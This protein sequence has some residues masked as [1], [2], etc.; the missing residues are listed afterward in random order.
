[1]LK[2][3]LKGLG[4]VVLVIVLGLAVVIASNWTYLNRLATFDR[5]TMITDYDWYDPIEIAKGDEGAP[6]PRAPQGAL[7]LQDTTIADALSF[8]ARNRS[9]ALLVWHKGTLQVEHY[10]EGYNRDTR[11]NSASMHKSVMALLYGVVIAEGIIPSLDEPAATYITE[12]ADDDRSQVTI[13]NLLQMASGLGRAPFSMNPFSDTFKLMM[14]T[15]INSLILKYPLED[16]PNTVF[17]YSNNNSEILGLIL[18][19]ASGMRY[20]DLLESKLWRK[21]G[22]RDAHVWLDSENGK[23]RTSGSLFI[24]AEDWMRV[25]LLHLNKGQVDGAQIVSEDWLKEVITPSAT[26]PNYGLQTWLGTEWQE[27]RTYGKG[28]PTGVPH[29]EDFAADDLFYFDGS[30]GQ[31]VYV[32]P[33]EDMVIVHTGNGGINPNTGNFDWDEALLPNMILRGIKR[34]ASSPM[35]DSATEESNTATD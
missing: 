7:T 13:R 20:A 5:N 33:S 24:T 31:R 35:M 10:G 11:T 28:V 22:T 15:D 29:S 27:L 8:A 4:I 26:N 6:L 25:G 32:I 19:R 21:L 18:E 12:W 1:M 2:K 16:T 17:A 14:G 9:T 3:I 23:A 30:G 34:D